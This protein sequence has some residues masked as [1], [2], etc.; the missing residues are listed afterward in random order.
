MGR[1]PVRLGCKVT[2]DE[3]LQELTARQPEIV[4]LGISF[5]VQ[6]E[7]LTALRMHVADMVLALD[8][9][10][11]KAIVA[12]LGY[13]VPRSLEGTVGMSFVVKPH[14]RCAG[15]GVVVVQEGRIRLGSGYASIVEELVVDEDGRVPPRDFKVYCFGHRPKLVQVIDRPRSRYSY[16]L[17][18]D[19]RPVHGVCRRK[20]Q[21]HPRPGR[22]D[23]LV[24]MS[25][26]LCQQFHFP[27]RIDC[28][29]SQ[30]G[31]VF[32]EFCI[33][34]GISRWLTPAADKLFGAW[35]ADHF[36]QQGIED[37]FDP[38]SAPQA[39]LPSYAVARAKAGL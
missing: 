18:D 14:A 30:V 20:W 6:R 27:V 15:A 28:Y 35:W 17:P 5:Q 2:A 31:V 38:Q 36:V 19:W 21:D 22:L 39:F 7:M 25:R 1:T 29:C 33:T 16:Y 24:A 11:A 32:G 3:L 34:S 4:R 37:W 8:K 10:K 23:A 12:E 13:Q 26:V 9:R